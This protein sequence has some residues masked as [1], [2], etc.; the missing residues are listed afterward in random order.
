VTNSIVD[1]PGARLDPFV[2]NGVLEDS[3]TVLIS[4]WETV[5]VETFAFGPY[6]SL[7]YRFTFDDLSID[8]AAETRL[9]W[10]VA[11]PHA[12]QSMWT[13]GGILR[14]MYAL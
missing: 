7:G 2:A 3:A 9:L 1:P 10:P 5:D 6:A 11:I 13:Y 4:S 8:L 14:V 12:T